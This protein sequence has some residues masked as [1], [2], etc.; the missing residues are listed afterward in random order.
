MKT[1]FKPLPAG[2][3]VALFLTL[4]AC[5]SGEEDCGGAC[6]AGT[7]CDPATGQCVIDGSDASDPSDPN[8]CTNDGDCLDST[9]QCVEGACISKCEGVSCDATLGEV[10]D[11]T[12]G[13]CVGGRGC[14]ADDDCDENF[15]CDAG[16]CKG[17]PFA[18]C[19]SASCIEGLNCIAAP[20][21]Q[22]CMQPCT[23][24]EECP[25]AQRCVVD[26]SGPAE[27]IANHCMINF[28]RPGGD[29]FGFFQ[30]ADYGGPC[31]ADG[32]DDGWCVGPFL[33]GDGNLQ[34]ICLGAD[35]GIEQGETCDPSATHNASTACNQGLCIEENATCAT[36]CDLFDDVSCP[37][38]TVCIPIWAGNGVCITHNPG[39]LAEVGENCGD[40]PG[41]LTC[42]EG[43]GCGPRGF[44][45]GAE[46]ICL[47][48]CL[49]DAQSGGQGTCESGTCTGYTEDNPT[50]GVCLTE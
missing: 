18:S 49:T 41:A 25:L 45:P 6:G 44:Q 30:D 39:V 35:G 42:V 46:N 50:I 36:F 22:V 29:M 10:C 7:V 40:T 24:Y 33:G 13:A 43:S 26:P 38:A 21:G 48:Y 12:T 31:D 8:A 5:S 23:T 17:G 37:S 2:L 34:G 1:A 9:L 4:T 14:S 3:F 15:V 28:C 47:A 27:S 19:A 20:F 32:E 11:P 16:E